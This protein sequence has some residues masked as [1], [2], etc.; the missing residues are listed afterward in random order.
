M[1]VAMAGTAFATDPTSD[2]PFTFT[3]DAG[4]NGIPAPSASTSAGASVW[5]YQDAS[6][7]KAKTEGS[8]EKFEDA[9]GNGGI[10][11]YTTNPHGGYSTTSNKCK[12]CHAVH[13]ANG[14]FAL[15]RV[16]SP[17]DACN[18]CHIGSHRHA[19]SEAYFGGGNGI[20]S[21]NG[22]TIGSGKSIP[23]SSIW[24]W[25]EDVTLT[26]DAGAVTFP[27]RRYLTEKNKIMRFIVHG[28]RYIRVGP[29]QLRCASC[30]QVHNAT[31]QIWKPK[32]SGYGPAGGA[33]VAGDVMTGGYK[34]LRN[35]PSGGLAVNPADIN[36]NG[37]LDLAGPGP[38]ASSRINSTYYDPGNAGQLDGL[39]NSSVDYRLKVVEK[40]VDPS[41][42]TE[43][44][45]GNPIMGANV[46]G[47]TPWKYLDT[48]N[49]ASQDVTSMPV[50]E[51]S[52]SFWCADCHN[53][54]IAG[55]AL[56]A[57]FGTGRTGESMLGDRSHAVPSQLRTN[58]SGN[59]AAAGTHCSQC[60]NSD[61]PLDATPLFVGADCGGCHVTTQM[62]HYYKNE[63]AV[64]GQT[65]AQRNDTRA[66][67]TSETARSDWPHAGPDWGRKLLNARDRKI[68]SG[69]TTNNW[70]TN[71][72][73]HID[74]AVT[75]D[76]QGSAIDFAAGDGQDKVCKT[77]HSG[78]KKREIGFDK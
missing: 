8:Y 70:T 52:M 31:Q 15:M 62:H 26:G 73:L 37:T 30:H 59:V 46:T 24:Q 69:G 14:S 39:A 61:M 53:L 41:T 12:T 64:G 67:D 58:A 7:A 48:T 10:G 77:C 18:Y 23:D 49:I 11:T 2:T 76:T 75:Y 5:S 1:M 50:Y 16:D 25:T 29:N 55:K 19:S 4:Q 60:H 71:P 20:Y 40:D 27:V 54:N 32:W 38:R 68:V 72:A 66:R 65:W 22:H 78:Y 3:E 74:G 57:G 28:G 33:L 51:T 36:G 44:V 43:A 9:A 34:L 42:G 56:A 35:S 21:T 17:D 47:Y 63:I 13:R 45:T 6:D